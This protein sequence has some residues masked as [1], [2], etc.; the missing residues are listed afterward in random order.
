MVTF[1]FCKKK[2]IFQKLAYLSPNKTSFTLEF[3][4]N[5]IFVFVYKDVNK[6]LVFKTLQLQQNIKVE[7]ERFTRRF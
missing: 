4:K 2:I 3:Q 6:G 5:F 7:K 1:L